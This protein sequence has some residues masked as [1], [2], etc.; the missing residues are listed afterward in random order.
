M[1][2]FDLFVY[3]K[4]FYDSFFYVEKLTKRQ[5]LN[6]IF[7]KLDALYEKKPDKYL[8]D[9]DSCIAAGQLFTGQGESHR[10]SVFL[11]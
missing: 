1:L 11:Q 10:N 8:T 9:E 5:R 4:S 7:E 2:L 6:I 3:L